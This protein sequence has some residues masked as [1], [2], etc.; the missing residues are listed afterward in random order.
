MGMQVVRIDHDDGWTSLTLHRPEKLDALTVA[1]FGELRDHVV[2]LGTGE[3]VRCG[4]VRGDGRCFSAGH[5]LQG[6]SG[7]ERVPS[8]G[9]HSE[10]LGLL[11]TLTV[12][13]IADVRGHCDPG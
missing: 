12:P 5:D 7:G 8:R 9:W 2:D 4:A 1:V 3:S 10:T 11:E 13:V 6:T